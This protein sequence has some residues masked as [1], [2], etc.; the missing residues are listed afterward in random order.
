[1]AI[2][3]SAA[4]LDELELVHH[5][6]QQAVDDTTRAGR[7][8][9]EFHDVMYAAARNR[10]LQETATNLRDTLGRFRVATLASP[11]RRREHV[12]E[13]GQLLEALKQHDPELAESTA[14]QHIRHAREVGLEMLRG[15]D[16][17]A[18]AGRRRSARS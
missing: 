13:Q 4:E 18:M 5:A 15:L 10:L 12:A 2:N 14:R 8:L 17:T 1:V 7:L 16:P 3:A 9:D 11:E 6:M